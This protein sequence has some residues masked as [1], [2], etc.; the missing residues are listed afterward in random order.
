MKPGHWVLLVCGVLLSLSGLG[1]AIGG[2]WLLAADAAQQGGRYVSGPAERHQTAG[3]ALTTPSLAVDPGQAGLP[4]APRL[5]DLA[6]V[7]VRVTPVV[8]D[9]EIFVGI[10]K[11]SEVA[12]YLDGVPHA[13]LGDRSRTDGGRWDEQDGWDDEDGEAEQGGTRAPASPAGQD[14]WAASASGAGAR[15]LTWDLQP[16][17]WSLVVMNADATRPVWVDLQAGVRSG[18]L[19]PVGT[20]VLVGGLAGLVVGVP[21]LLLGSAGLGRDIGTSGARPGTGPGAAL[22]GS[23]GGDGSD[24]ASAVYPV[25]L[26]GWLDSKLSRGLWLVKWLLAIPHYLILALLW[27]ALLVTTIAAGIAILFTGRYPQSWFSFCTGVL[28]WTWRVGFYAYS[29]LGTDRYPPF[30]L[31][32]ADYPADFEVDYPARLSRGLVLVKWWLLAIPHVLVVAILT[33]SIGTRWDEDNG[34]GS[35]GPSLLGLLVLIAAV[36][37]LFTGRYRQGLFDLVMGINRWAWRVGAYVLLLRDEY[38]PF[39][40]DQGPAEPPAPPPPPAA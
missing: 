39:R 26:L 2:T 8:P 37:L 13:A 38:P 11:A 6:S 9:Q 30:T 3:Y 1:L 32:R 22:A 36:I 19:G 5:G 34:G 29:A 23:A 33:G 18:L 24:T 40:L 7:Q 31:A 17:T 35:W 10:A 28:R 16:G 20:G 25:R 27:F 4:G 21:L 12:A 14:F 15:E